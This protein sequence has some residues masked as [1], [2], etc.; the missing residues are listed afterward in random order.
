MLE[1]LE[2]Y[3]SQSY[4]IKRRSITVRARPGVRAVKFSFV[5]QV[6]VPYGLTKSCRARTCIPGRYWVGPMTRPLS[7]HTVFIHQ[8]GV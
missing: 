4:T 1:S 8:S 6:F 7:I 5:D 2:T 3:H